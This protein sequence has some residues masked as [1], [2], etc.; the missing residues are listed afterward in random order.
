MD[1]SNILRFRTAPQRLRAIAFMEGVSFLLLLLVAM[2]LKYF[3]GIKLGVSIVGTLHGFLF[4]L[5]ACLTL[6][7]IIIYKKK[8][9][10]GFKI[11]LASV[12]PLGTFFLDKELSDL[13]H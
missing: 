2:P 10:W 7:A 11:G 6:H 9:F 13:G 3:A 1:V 12:I 8:L 5:L 4:V